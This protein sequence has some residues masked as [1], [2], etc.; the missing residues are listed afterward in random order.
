MAQFISEMMQEYKINIR[1]DLQLFTHLKKNLI[2]LLKLHKKQTCFPRLKL[3]YVTDI[4]KN[5]LL[6]ELLVACTTLEIRYDVVT[7]ISFLF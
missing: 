1:Y 6:L 3:I 2:M 5:L 4:F 7:Q